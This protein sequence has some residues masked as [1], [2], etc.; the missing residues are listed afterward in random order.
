VYP[1]SKKKV[2]TPIDHKSTGFPCPIFL[3]TSGAMY[4]G[5][6]QVVINASNFSGS[7]IWCLKLLKTNLA[8]SEISEQ[9]LSIRIPRFEQQVL[10]FNVTMND[11]VAMQVPDGIQNRGLNMKK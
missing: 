5:V 7:I 8:Q 2:K 3:I 1:Q 9:Q 10:R 6:P 4:P 11:V